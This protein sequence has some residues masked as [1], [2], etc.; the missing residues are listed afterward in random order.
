MEGG[1]FEQKK[2]WRSKILQR[3]LCRRLGA[4]RS[5]WAFAVGFPE[6]LRR[7]LI[8]LRYDWI[9]PPPTTTLY[10]ANHADRPYGNDNA[11]NHEVRAH[12]DH[13]IPSSD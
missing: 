12:P 6:G 8:R 4:G 1:H 13:V 2:L 5:L 9:A 11:D 7:R 3:A 10:Q